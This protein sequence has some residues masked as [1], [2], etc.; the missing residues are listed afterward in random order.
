[1]RGVGSV[2]LL[3][4]LTVAPVRALPPADTIPSRGGP[5]RIQPIFHASTQIE[6]AG[7]VIQIDPWSQGDYSRAKRADLILI[8][9]IHP[10]HLDRAALA[11]VRKAGT[12]IVGPKAVARELPGIAVLRNYERTT[13]YGISIEAVPMYNL[14]RGP[15]P[16]QLY[17]TKGRGN[18]YVLTLGGKRLYFSGD[19]ENIPEARRLRNVDVAFVCMNLPYTMTPTEAAAMV[20]AFRPRI[21]YPYHY[22]GSDREAFRSALKG[23]PIEVRLRDWYAG[24]QR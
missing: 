9:D 7:K 20:R 1:M 3:V 6:H 21:V 12:V 8:T 13:I 18:G 22:R 14:K 23:A 11:K 16:G 17:H 4:F 19:T 10:D 5:I 2:L 15:A 24:P